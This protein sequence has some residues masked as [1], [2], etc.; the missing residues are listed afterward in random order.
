[1]VRLHALGRDAEAVSVGERARDLYAKLAG[2][3]SGQMALVL[4]DLSEP[5]I[6]LRRFDQAHADIERAIADLERQ[7]RAVLR[8]VRPARS[9]RRLEIAEG[10]GRE[11]G[12]DLDQA[13]AMLGDTDGGAEARFELARALWSGPRDRRRSL[14]LATAAESSFCKAP[15]EARNLKELRTWLESRRGP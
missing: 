9:A 8:R 6:A 14:A 3:D 15:S 11:A 12:A 13:V 5:L 7:R 2:D 1:M 4:L 10:H